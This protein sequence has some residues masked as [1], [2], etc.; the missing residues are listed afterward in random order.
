MEDAAIHMQTRALGYERRE[1]KSFFSF[2]DSLQSTILTNVK[3]VFVE[4][5][6]TNSS[7]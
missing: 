6:Y 5:G 3:R 1:I 7:L 4:V 2:L